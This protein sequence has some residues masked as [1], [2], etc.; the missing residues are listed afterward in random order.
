MRIRVR[1]RIVY[2][3]LSSILYFCSKKAKI[4]MIISVVLRKFF[5]LLNIIPSCDILSL[6]LVGR[7]ISNK[8]MLFRP[9]MFI[10]SIR[11][12]WWWQHYNV[13]EMVLHLYP[14][15]TRF[16]LTRAMWIG[17]VNI[18]ANNLLLYIEN[19]YWKFSHEI[20]Y[21]NMNSSRGKSQDSRSKI[22]LFFTSLSLA[23][24]R[25]V[26]K[27]KNKQWNSLMIRFDVFHNVAHLS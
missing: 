20:S 24:T 6:S 16:G 12:T 2:L 22:S 10:P 9:I 26:M 21:Q 19:P 4:F 14:C 7:I 1:C 25:T 3:W 27:V 5:V 23:N 13:L 8:R 17:S 15:M 11:P 18:A